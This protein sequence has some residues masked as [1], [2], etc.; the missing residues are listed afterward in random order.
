VP[1]MVQ[2]ASWSEMESARANEMLVVRGGDWSEGL[3][4]AGNWSEKLP[5]SRERDVLLVMV[6]TG[7][8]SRPH[9]ESWCRGQH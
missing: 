8:F 7:V 1:H 4:L 3:P 9:L 6:L 2:L 5:T